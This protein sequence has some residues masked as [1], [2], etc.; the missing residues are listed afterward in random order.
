[1]S[2]SEIAM[3]KME[4]A[5]LQ[6]DLEDL[7]KK[8][9][10]RDTKY[11]EIADLQDPEFRNRRKDYFINEKVIPLVNE[12]KQVGDYLK[13]MYDNGIALEEQ[14]NHRITEYTNNI[15][16]FN[17]TIS[18]FDSKEKKEE[19]KINLLEREHQILKYKTYIYDETI[20]LLYIMSIVLIVCC[21][22]VL[23]NYLSIVDRV[24]VC[25]VLIVIILLYILYVVK[26]IVIDRVN[27]NNYFYR[28]ID[29]NKPTKDEIKKNDDEDSTYQVYTE[30]NGRDEC[31]VKDNVGKGSF[32]ESDDDLL[33]EVISDI[34]T[35]KSKNADRCLITR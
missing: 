26:I 12:R 35:T 4:Y 30:V 17:E 10:N 33:A 23:S 21:L 8:L 5:R 20:H 2:D 22:V 1:M 7:Q 11:L 16:R 13:R 31:D 19:D 18:K 27:I 14:I 3:K 28:N 15:E 6:E 25:C 29:F 9:Q 34:D 32:Y 24:I